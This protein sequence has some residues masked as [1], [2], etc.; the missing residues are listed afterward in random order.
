[1]PSYSIP[2]SNNE[3]SKNSSSGSG[4]YN[5]EDKKDVTPRKSSSIPRPKSLGPKPMVPPKP[6]SIR[7]AVSN[8]TRRPTN[9]SSRSYDRL[10]IHFYIMNKKEI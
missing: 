3:K 7:R 6:A 4:N 5:I 8:L 10:V 2:P 1:M 9:F